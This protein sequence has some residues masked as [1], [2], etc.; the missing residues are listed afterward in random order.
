MPKYQKPFKLSPAGRRFHYAGRKTLSLLLLAMVLG[1]LVAA[2]RFGAFGSKPVPDWSK[3]HN[4]TFR[5][6]RAVDGDTFHL[7]VSDGKHKTTCVR[8]WGVDTPETVRPNSPVE[9]FGP[10]ASAFTKNCTL[11]RTVRIELED[12]KDARDR[13]GRLLAWAYLDD[14]RLLNGLLI[15]EGYGYAD[16]RFDHHLQRSLRSLQTK[17][18]KAKVGLWKDGLPKDLPYYYT[19]GKYKLPRP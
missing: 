2:D 5:V 17:A 10:E 18:I 13:H 6:A 14:G 3:Y 7:D 9:Y 1:G 15:E 12:G 16:P 19:E 4:Q 11:G 8:L